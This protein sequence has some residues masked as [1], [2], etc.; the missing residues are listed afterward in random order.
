[1]RHLLS[2]LDRYYLRPG[3]ECIS[4]FLKAH[5][6]SRIENG[7]ANPSLNAMEVIATALGLSIFELWDEVRRS[8]E[9]KPAQRA[10]L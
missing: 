7:H 1:V 8:A 5:P 10:R 4:T 6:L 9:T 3:P 2:D